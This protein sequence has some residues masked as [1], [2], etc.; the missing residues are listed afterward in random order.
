[1]ER[2]QPEHRDFFPLKI[3]F[4]VCF[5]THTEIVSQYQ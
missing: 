3:G 1:M 2:F 4:V 5:W